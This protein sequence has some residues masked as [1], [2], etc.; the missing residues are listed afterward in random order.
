MVSPQ[1]ALILY[2]YYQN[3]NQQTIPNVDNIVRLGCSGRIYL[4]N[5]VDSSR[6]QD[7]IQ[8]LGLSGC[9]TTIE[10]EQTLNH[11]FGKM[12]LGII[13][14]SSQL[15]DMT[16]S[17]GLAYSQWLP[18]TTTLDQ[19]E[20]YIHDGLDTAGEYD[21]DFLLVDM[22]DQSW[23]W[24]D[25][26]MG[27]WLEQSTILKCIVTRYHCEQIETGNELV[28]QSHEYKNGVR[29]KVKQD[30]RYLCAYFHDGSTRV[31]TVNKFDMEQMDRL[32]C[33]GSILAWHYLAE[34]GH[35]LGYVPKYGA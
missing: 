2:N 16:R 34:I 18:T 23:Q 17:A 1:K 19:L 15:I 25:A 21:L 9:S 5:N 6:S 20:A 13:S 8:L 32:G 12:K 31:D 3:D 28:P 33:N 26:I 7:I 11:R 30:I 24:T 27:K 29:I 14:N 22:T 10:M 4:E 35:K